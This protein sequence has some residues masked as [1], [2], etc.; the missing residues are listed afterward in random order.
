MKNAFNELVTRLKLVAYSL[1][2]PTYNPLEIGQKHHWT[3]DEQLKSYSDTCR[4]LHRDVNDCIELLKI[5]IEEVSNRKQ[6]PWEFEYFVPEQEVRQEYGDL[7]EEVIDAK[8]TMVGLGLKRDDFPSMFNE[9]IAKA[10][11]EINGNP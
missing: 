10:K 8:E 3:K 6:E 7:L 1:E 2:N 4:Y 9:L 5:L 11:G